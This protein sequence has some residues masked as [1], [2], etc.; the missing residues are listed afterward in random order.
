MAKNILIDVTRIYNLLLKGKSLTGVDRVTIA[1]IKNF[2]QTSLAFLFLRNKALVLDKPQ[3]SK[4]FDWILHP[5]KPSKLFNITF[6]HRVKNFY[7]KI[8]E[9]AVLFNVSHAN[10]EKTSY[11]SVTKKLNLNLVILVHD[12]IPI[13]HHEHCTAQAYQRHISR[14][15]NILNNAAGIICNSGSTFNELNNFASAHNLPMPPTLAALL[16][17]SI[18]KDD[19]DCIRP[20]NLPYFVILGTIESRKN[21]FFILKIWRK[22][23]ERYNTKAPRLI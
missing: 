11:W 2:S 1:Y 21:H 8:P 10:L 13:T 18:A 22:I 23:I 4:L 7:I 9:N 6:L 14:I 15:F 12:L 3:S 20:V 16:G 5:H 19:F 17:S